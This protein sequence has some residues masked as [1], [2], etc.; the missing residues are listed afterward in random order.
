M[1]YVN[2]ID[3]KLAFPNS[4]HSSLYVNVNILLEIVHHLS[5][6]LGIYPKWVYYKSYFRLELVRCE[7]FE[8]KCNMW[9]SFQIQ[10]H[11][12][13]VHVNNFNKTTKIAA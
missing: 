6:L 11:K 1:S 9:D 2:P 10:K 7:T 8:L 5:I 13:H 4:L 3:T 12:L